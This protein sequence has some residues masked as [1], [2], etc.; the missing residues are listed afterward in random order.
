MI[1]S[2]KARLDVARALVKR[3]DDAGKVPAGMTPVGGAAVSLQT[4]PAGW[5]M[6]RAALARQ[7]TVR[8]D[9]RDEPNQMSTSYC[10]QAAFLYCML[11]DRPDLYVAYAIGLWAKGEYD[12]SSGTKHLHIASDPGAKTAMKDFPTARKAHPT[13]TISELD[14]ITM[15]SLSTSTRPLNRLLGSPKPSDQGASISY[16]WIVKDWF[17]NLG[18]PARVDTMGW[19]VATIPVATFLNLMNQWAACWIVL[20][21]DASLLNGGGPRF[22]TGR[23][24]VVVDPHRA[25]MVRLGDGGKVVPLGAAAAKIWDVPMPVIESGNVLDGPLMQNWV[26]NLRLVSWGHENYAMARQQIGHLV[27]RIYG[28]F[29]FPRFR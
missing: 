20:Q 15:S 12:F 29:A 26:T 27:G 16:P 7:L 11:E 22:F 21:I 17:S 8:L 19:G 18:A 23:H 25:P 10:G 13:T 24:W 2:N 5:P 6:T 14:W 3:F 1:V 4:S 28:G 9:G